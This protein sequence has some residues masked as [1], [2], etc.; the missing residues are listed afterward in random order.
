MLILKLTHEE[1]IEKFFGDP[2][3]FDEF[4]GEGLR[5]AEVSDTGSATLELSDGEGKEY[6]VV[7]S[8]HFDI[9]E[10]KDGRA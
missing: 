2:E 9:K 3:E 8:L 7:V 6:E 5:W 10:K 4:M 1:V